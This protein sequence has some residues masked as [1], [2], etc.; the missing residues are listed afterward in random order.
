MTVGTTPAA[1]GAEP[2]EYPVDF[3]EWCHGVPAYYR[4]LPAG[5]REELRKSG[6]LLAKRMRQEWSDEFKVF[7]GEAKP[8]NAPKD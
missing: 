8:D 7:C 2:D 3:D 5:F 4:P 6:R 1:P